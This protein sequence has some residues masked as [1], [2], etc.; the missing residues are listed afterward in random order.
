MLFLGLIKVENIFKNQKLKL[1]L[2]TTKSFQSIQKIL[3]FNFR[4]KFFKLYPRNY[5]FFAM[6]A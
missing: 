5:I 6:P 3:F 4:Q 1:Q 2:A